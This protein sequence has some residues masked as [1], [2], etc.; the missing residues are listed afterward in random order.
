[1]IPTLQNYRYTPEYQGLPLEQINQAL[2]SNEKE[3][4]EQRGEFTKLAGFLGQIKT[5]NQGNEYVN[6][7]IKQYQDAINGLGQTLQKD[8][9][10]DRAGV[11][12]NTMAQDLSSDTKLHGIIE[13]WKRNEEDLKIKAALRAKGETPV[14]LGDDYESFNN[15]DENGSVKF[16][17]PQTQPKSDY[18]SEINEYWKSYKPDLIESGFNMSN[19]D[20]YLEN[21][22]L[23]SNVDKIRKANNTVTD[24]WE[25]SSSGEQYK[26]ILKKEN[27][28][29]SDSEIKRL[30]SIMVRK[31]GSG[32]EVSS[33]KKEYM[34]DQQQKLE[35]D[36]KRAGLIEQA[37]LSARK[38]IKAS[39]KS[40]N[41]EIDNDGKEINLFQLGGNSVSKD[42]T[43]YG[44]EMLINNA[45]LFTSIKNTYLGN[46]IPSAN[47]FYNLSS[48]K[49]TET[50]IGEGVES[51][52]PVGFN[53]V[54]VSGKEEFNGG[55]IANVKTKSGTY[56]TII[57]LGSSNPILPY[58][59]TLNNYDKKIRINLK[60][61]NKTIIDDT[62]GLIR[63]KDDNGND[64]NI[65]TG[66][67]MEASNPSDI[68]KSNFL[69]RPVY[70]N[71]KGQWQHF[72]KEDK[73]K[74]FMKDSY[75]KDDL[76]KETMLKAQGVFANQ[77][78]SKHTDK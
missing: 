25:S 77:V 38:N 20:G 64:R 17:N 3:F 67:E 2:Q 11:I 59:Q 5:N 1:M 22:V 65:E 63:V 24:L 34:A 28:N 72:N 4:V 68:K 39:R 57:N 53:L 19:L 60:G 16:F 75:T 62:S 78:V 14:S 13:N 33:V 73:N 12:V 42:G 21:T 23:N 55:L 31:V 48:D 15:F 27:P 26:K 51:V 54:D 66:F 6:S 41:V 69:L 8:K 47:N 35:N 18:V 32:N 56:K 40:N 61:G 43:T 71:L 7:K 76:Y 49:S 30:M 9:R 29:A 45:E 50:I 37:K 52:T 70:K 44:K 36:V 74:F 46:Q 58:I 10:W